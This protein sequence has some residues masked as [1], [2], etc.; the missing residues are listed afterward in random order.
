MESNKDTDDTPNAGFPIPV[1]IDWDGLTT[2]LRK[3]HEQAM[4]TGDR[5][6]IEKFFTNSAKLGQVFSITLVCEDSFLSQQLWESVKKGST[7]RIA[8]CKV[9]TI[10]NGDIGNNLL[11]V[12]KKLAEINAV[13]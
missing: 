2:K 8:G 10:F 11:I 5:N 9:V 13:L 7:M 3:A 12:K 1:P 4:A 6:Y